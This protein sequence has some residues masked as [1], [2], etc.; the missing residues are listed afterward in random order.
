MNLRDWPA[1]IDGTTTFPRLMN[2]AELS[3]EDRNRF[4]DRLSRRGIAVL[5]KRKNPKREKLDPDVLAYEEV[6][7]A[8][9]GF[10]KQVDDAL[11]IPS[12]YRRYTSKGYVEGLRSWACELLRLGVNAGDWLRQAERVLREA[13][14][15]PSVKFSPNYM[16]SDGVSGRVSMSLFERGRHFNDKNA[17][18]SKV[19]A[20]AGENDSRALDFLRTLEGFDLNEHDQTA[21]NVMVSYA[22]SVAKGDAMRVPRRVR[23]F[24]DALS[25]QPWIGDL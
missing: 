10:R 25:S 1:I 20:Y 5:K 4:A 11:G 3:E 19:N 12:A 23:P 14:Q 18:R 15:P 13:P 21:I 17:G 2:F 22:K 6:H 9:A 16:F 7:R 8:Y 24:V